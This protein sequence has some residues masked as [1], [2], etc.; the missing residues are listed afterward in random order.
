VCGKIDKHFSRPLRKK[1]K[2]RLDM[3]WGENMQKKP[4]TLADVIYRFGRHTMAHGFRGKG[5]YLTED[6]KIEWEFIDCALYLNPYWFWRTFTAVYEQGWAALFENKEPTN[7]LKR[8]ADQ[9]LAEIL[10]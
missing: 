6:K 10:E 5:V 4:E 9:Y 1:D 7:T 2:K 8:S 3:L